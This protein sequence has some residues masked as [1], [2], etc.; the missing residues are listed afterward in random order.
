MDC[1]WTATEF[2]T[3]QCQ[4]QFRRSPDS[5]RTEPVCGLHDAHTDQ[6]DH[7]SQCRPGRNRL[8]GTYEKV[9]EGVYTYT[10]ATAFPADYDKTVT[11]TVAMYGSRNLSEFDLGTQYDNVDYS[12]VPNGS[13][14]TVVRDVVRTETCNKCHDPLAE[15][16]AAGAKCCSVIRAILRRP[17]I[18]TRARPLT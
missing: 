11:H 3:R 15:H 5:G 9:S 8:R 16:G 1:L 4:H 7:G 18:P 12:W 2:N 14:V 10:F 17:R 6:P 13:P